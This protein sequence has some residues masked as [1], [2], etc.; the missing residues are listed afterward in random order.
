[1]GPTLV[2]NNNSLQE[3]TGVCGAAVDWNNDGDVTDTN[4][5]ANA[6]DNAV[7][8]ETLRDF[9]NWRALRFNGPRADGSQGN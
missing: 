9:G 6:D 8:N 7:A 5:S 1:M 3:A 2:E 4:L